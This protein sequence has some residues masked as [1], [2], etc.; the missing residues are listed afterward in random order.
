MLVAVDRKG[1]NNVQWTVSVESSPDFSSAEI[2]VAYLG[3]Q[4]IIFVFE[5]DADARAACDSAF[6]AFPGQVVCNGLSLNFEHIVSIP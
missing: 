4:R 2:A 1:E 3:V 6:P 5:G